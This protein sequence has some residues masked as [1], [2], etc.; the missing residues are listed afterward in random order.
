MSKVAVLL[1]RGYRKKQ[2][3]CDAIR[4]I[5]FDLLQCRRDVMANVP[6]QSGDRFVL[7]QPF[8][9]KE[10]LNQLSAVEL[11][12]CAHVAQVLRTSEAHQPLHYKDIS[13]I[14]GS[15]DNARSKLDPLFQKK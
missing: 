1:L 8:N 6:A 13:L 7:V 11:S 4:K 2:K 10:W 15:S 9:D 5:F 12:L 14:H 3:L